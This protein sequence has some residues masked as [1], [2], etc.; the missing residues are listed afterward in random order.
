MVY[1]I[2]NI[3][4]LEKFY[5]S[6]FAVYMGARISTL[7]KDILAIIVTNLVHDYY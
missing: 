2:H 6:T 7:L 4:R 5:F 1:F 3:W